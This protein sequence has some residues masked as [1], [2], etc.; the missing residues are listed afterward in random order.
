MFE[1]DEGLD[2]QEKLDEVCE[3]LES[4]KTAPVS[5]IRK[6]LAQSIKLMD[7]IEHFKDGATKVEEENQEIGTLK[8]ALE[9]TKESV[10]TK[11]MTKASLKDERY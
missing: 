11:R 3:S 8:E 9:Q 10:E 6:S 1:T 7:Q 5:T 4:A 2:L